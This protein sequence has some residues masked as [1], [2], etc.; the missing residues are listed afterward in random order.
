MLDH[1]YRSGTFLQL[2]SKSEFSPARFDEK[3]EENSFK[4]TDHF[5]GE[6]KYFSECIL[7]NESPELNAEE[8]FADVR[9]LEGFVF[10]Q[11]IDRLS[12]VGGCSRHR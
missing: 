5:G 1:K 4:N 11:E 8:G 3:K 2:G 7:N 12:W 10:D 6:L 9:V